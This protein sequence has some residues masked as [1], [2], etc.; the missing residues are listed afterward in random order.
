MSDIWVTKASELCLLRDGSDMEF[1]VK[2]GNL[3]KEML[4]TKAYKVVAK[5]GMHL[6]S[7][8]AERGHIVSLEVI[9]SSHKFVTTFTPVTQRLCVTLCMPIRIAE[10]AAY[11]PVARMDEAIEWVEGGK[12]WGVVL[13]KLVMKE[14]GGYKPKFKH[15]PLGEEAQYPEDNPATRR[16]R[17]VAVGRTW[18]VNI[19]VKED[20]EYSVD[21]I[22]RG[23]TSLELQVPADILAEAKRLTAIQVAKVRGK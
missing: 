15:K 5:A 3:V 10:K 1:F 20:F 9:Y 2:F 17:A 12:G 22:V 8:L 11:W 7:G 19:T 14:K 13:E 18:I 6:A 21:G 16:G 23:L 4:A